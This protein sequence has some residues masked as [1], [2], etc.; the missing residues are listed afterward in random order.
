MSNEF[1]LHIHTYILS[2]TTTPSS[3]QKHE[4]ELCCMGLCLMNLYY[5]YTYILSSTT[6]PSEFLFGTCSREARQLGQPLRE[7]DLRVNVQPL[8][9]EF[10]AFFLEAV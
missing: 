10:Q 8:E 7:M 1:I 2:S 4:I 9:V 3:L 6:T 5:I